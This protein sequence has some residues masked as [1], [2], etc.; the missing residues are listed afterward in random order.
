MNLIGKFLYPKI[1]QV[2][3]IFREHF[4]LKSIGKSADTT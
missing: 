4:V 1:N 3:E 2:F